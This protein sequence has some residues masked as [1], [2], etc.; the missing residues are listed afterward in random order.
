M[1]HAFCLRHVLENFN[2]KFK[3]KQYK[4][5][6]WLMSKA[7]THEVFDTNALQI[8]TEAIHWLESV[9]YPHISLLYSPVC[10]FG[11]VTSNNVE[12]VN[13][14]IARLRTLPIIEMLLGIEDMVL[15]DRLRDNASVRKCL[16]TAG[17]P[18][19]GRNRFTQYAF[20]AYQKLDAGLAQAG[21]SSTQFAETEY[22]VELGRQKFQVSLDLNIGRCFC[23]CGKVALYKSPCIHVMFIV[24]DLDQRTKLYDESWKIGPWELA[25]RSFEQ[26]Y[27]LTLQSELIDDGLLPPFKSKKK[28]RPKKRRI[29]S[30][31]ATEALEAAPRRPVKCSRCN[32]FG[33]NKR[34]CIVTST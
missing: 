21:F 17:N 22:I 9:G 31:P 6:V 33:H 18:R 7:A 30:Q 34:G 3:N 12:S 10:R 4:K 1:H 2:L 26:S 23:S 8:G 27:P 15:Q 14:R 20:S 13:S 28:G 16:S 19:P 24:Q 29:C 5:H 25:S 11:V 32:Q